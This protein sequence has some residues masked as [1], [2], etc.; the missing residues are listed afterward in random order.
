MHTNNHKC[1]A[2]L[3]LRP[4]DDVDES[5]CATKSHESASNDSL[6]SM[7]Q[8][9]Q[10]SRNAEC[11]SSVMPDTTSSVDEGTRNNMHHD[12]DHIAERYEQQRDQRNNTVSYVYQTNSGVHGTD[13]IP[14]AQAYQYPS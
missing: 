8:N 5:A 14:A 10:I 12:T 13:H 9:F 7:P 6:R 3:R 4:L 2:G 1:I 11:Q